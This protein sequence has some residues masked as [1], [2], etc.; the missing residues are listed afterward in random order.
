MATSEYNTGN[1]KDLERD[2]W[3][4]RVGE[5]AQSLGQWPYQVTL[6]LLSNVDRYD[7]QSRTVYLKPRDDEPER[8]EYELGKFAGLLPGIG[9]VL[10]AYLWIGITMNIPEGYGLVSLVAVILSGVVAL[11]SIAAAGA[12][13]TSIDAKVASRGE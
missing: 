8:T 12:V 4:F 7:K 3:M 10:T 5:K 6:R 13:G 11:V 1:R 9:L 2:S